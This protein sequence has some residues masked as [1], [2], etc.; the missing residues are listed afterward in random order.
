MVVMNKFRSLFNKKMAIIGMIH[1]SALPGTPLF[2]PPIQK[3]IDKALKE[4]EIYL[5]NGVDS[6]LIENMHD[7]PYVQAKHFG[8][9]T[10]AMMSKIS[11]EIRILVPKST[12]L[13]I[14]ILACGNKEALAVAYAN[15]FNYIRAE[16]FVFSHIADEGFTDANAGTLLRYRASIGADKIM[17]LTDI[18]KKHSAHSITSDVSLL[19]TAKAAE[20]FLSDGII[21]TGTATGDPVNVKELSQL[22]GAVNL[23]ILIGSGVTVDNFELYKDAD[24]FIIGSHFKNDGIWWNNLEEARIKRFMEKINDVREK[25]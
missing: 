20:F 15:N 5:K 14:Q 3:I 1:V 18:K 24:A 13:G 8:P 2:R 12:P 10:V 17:I 16:G 23:P 11:S 21:L 19:E 4:T 22:T 7:I 6:I 9:E 25:Q